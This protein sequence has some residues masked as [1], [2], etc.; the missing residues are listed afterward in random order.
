L[1]KNILRKHYEKIVSFGYKEIGEIEEIGEIGE[2]V[3]VPLFPLFPLS[4]LALW[5]S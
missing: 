1:E 4:P 3:D 2:I 5:F